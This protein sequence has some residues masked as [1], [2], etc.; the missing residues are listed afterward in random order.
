MFD[1][2]QGFDA[3]ETEQVVDGERIGGLGLVVIRQVMDE[4][5]VECD[6]ETGTCV[7]MIKYRV[8]A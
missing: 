7:R 3:S 1:R 5:D 2:G 6:A 4:V 8:S